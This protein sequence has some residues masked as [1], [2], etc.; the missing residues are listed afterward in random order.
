MVRDALARSDSVLE[1]HSKKVISKS[2]LVFHLCRERIR[3][4]SKSFNIVAIKALFARILQDN[5]LN[6][7]RAGA[8]TNAHGV[9]LAIRVFFSETK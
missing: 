6:L 5:S 4:A 2:S 3:Y 9:L 8:K 7:R 1:P